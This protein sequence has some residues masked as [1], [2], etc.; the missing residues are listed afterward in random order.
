MIGS[1]DIVGAA[2]II[3]V[4]PTQYCGQAFGHSRVER[5]DHKAVRMAA[6]AAL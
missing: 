5:V 4:Q 2:T 6:Q 3:G 1:G